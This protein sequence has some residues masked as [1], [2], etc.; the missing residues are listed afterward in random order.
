M[1]QIL[2]TIFFSAAALAAFGIIVSMLVDNGADVR[3]AL[4]FVPVQR[5]P[6]ASGRTRR[7]ARMRPVSA[8]PLKSPR[9][10]A[11]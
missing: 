4:G 7:I 2:A 8:V 10:A 3:R 1:V 9:R 5:L 11:A 6:S